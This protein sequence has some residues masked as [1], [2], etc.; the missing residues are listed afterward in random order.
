MIAQ[1]HQRAQ[2]TT[3]YTFLVKKYTFLLFL[4]YYLRITGCPDSLGYV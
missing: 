1:I 2:M 4:T 3:F